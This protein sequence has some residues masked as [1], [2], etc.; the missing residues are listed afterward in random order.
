MAACALLLCALPAL[1][2]EHMVGEVA[3]PDATLRAQLSVDTAG[4]AH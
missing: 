2:A 1:A 3:S 4:T